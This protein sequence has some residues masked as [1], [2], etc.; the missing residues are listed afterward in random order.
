MTMQLTIS[1]LLRQAAI[2]PGEATLSLLEALDDDVRERMIVERSMRPRSW[3]R[4]IPGASG[5]RPARVPHQP[6]DQ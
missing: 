2:L 3:E 1:A 4:R 5:P 6:L